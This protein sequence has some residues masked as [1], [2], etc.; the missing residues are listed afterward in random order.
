M[1]K[2][3]FPPPKLPPGYNLPYHSIKKSRFEPVQSS[4]QY[5]KT[6]KQGLHRH[7]ITA[8]ERALILDEPLPNSLKDII[9]TSDQQKSSSLEKNY[10][11][12]D[13]NSSSINIKSEL[14]DEK[15]SNTHVFKPFVSNPDKQKRYEQFLKLAK[16]G[17]K[18]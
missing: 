18:G 5:D 7:D 3:F 6:K 10:E 17:Q 16:L 14:D 2:K 9:T 11:S 12:S 1:K 15:S 4:A 8:N 13:K